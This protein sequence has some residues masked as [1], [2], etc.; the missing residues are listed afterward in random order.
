MQLLLFVK[1]VTNT[2]LFYE[3][4]DGKTIY[5]PWELSK[6]FSRTDTHRCSKDESQGPTLPTGTVPRDV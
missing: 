5:V 6:V 2:S 4:C 3:L 1:L